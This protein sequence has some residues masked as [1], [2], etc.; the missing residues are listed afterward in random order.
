MLVLVNRAR[1]DSLSLSS[2]ILVVG[3]ED[4]TLLCMKGRTRGGEGWG[5]WVVGGRREIP[6]SCHPCLCFLGERV[7]LEARLIQAPSF[8]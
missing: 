7:N 8:G 2:L 1:L 4:R 3:C 6:S 5:G